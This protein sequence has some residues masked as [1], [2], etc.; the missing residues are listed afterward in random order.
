MK[1]F[2]MAAAAAFAALSLQAQDYPELGAK[3]K[4]YFTALAGE[5][6]TVQNQ[7]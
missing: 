6:V 1:K 3:L 4:E 2:L 7:E 5:S